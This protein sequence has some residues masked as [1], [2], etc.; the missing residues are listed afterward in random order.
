MTFPGTI[1]F[2]GRAGIAIAQVPVKKIWP[3]GPGF[4]WRIN[5]K[6]VR[7]TGKIPIAGNFANLIQEIYE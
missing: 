1:K 5:R 7:C 2:A 4:L 3:K 6:S